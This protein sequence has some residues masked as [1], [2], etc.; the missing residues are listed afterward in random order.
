MET[1][2]LAPGAK[3]VLLGVLFVMVVIGALWAFVWIT[4][5]RQDAAALTEKLEAIP[6]PA[7]LVLVDQWEYDGSFLAGG[8]PREAARAYIAPAD[9][10]STCDRIDSFYAELEISIGTM[11]RSDVSDDE[12]CG[13]TMRGR[14]ISIWVEEV[15]AYSLVPEEYR[16]RDDLVTVRFSAF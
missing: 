9:V 6:V 3:V 10:A 7:E 16:D 12:W 5:A 14:N 8:R 11:L 13:R 2:N 4:E 15:K 1:K